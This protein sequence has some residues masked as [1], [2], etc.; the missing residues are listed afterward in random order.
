[1]T[2]LIGQFRTENAA[3]QDGIAAAAAASPRLADLAQTH[4]L[5]FI[6]LATG[7]GDPAKRTAAIEA[8]VAGRRLR[9]VCDLAGIPY[10]LRAVPRELC[11]IP[12]PHAEW[13]SDASPVLAQFVPDDLTTLSNWVHG[14]FFVNGTGSEH[15]ALW[16]A[17]RHEL[18]SRSLLDHRH[19][20]PLAMMSW[21]VRHPS[22][23]LSDLIPRLWSPRA[24]SRRLL[25]TTRA[26]LFRVRCRVYLPGPA[27]PDGDVAPI[28]IGPYRAIELADYRSVLDEQ[29][30]M[31]NCLDRYGPRIASG[32]F[33]IFSLRTQAGERIANFEVGL[34]AREGPVVTEIQGRANAELPPIICDR[35]MQWVASA[36]PILR[37]AAVA[38]SSYPANAEA[39]FAELVSPYVESHRQELAEYGPVTLSGLEHD[40]SELGKRL[41]IR[42]WP[43]RYERTPNG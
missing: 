7:F 37:R 29:Q 8:A 11:P 20:L 22:H 38:T 6:A 32:A 31:D 28:E 10:C 17:N 27:T 3:L 5:L 40:I 4:P 42:N 43:V 26:W 34:Q 23:E 18:F 24:G 1:M 30:A 35:I 15:F 25:N 9:K 2:N 12:L 41:G 14:I 21:F 13:S 33:A 39:L 36:P 19:L 16:L